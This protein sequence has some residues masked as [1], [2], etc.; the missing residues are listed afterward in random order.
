MEDAYV[1]WGTEMVSLVQ[2]I[3]T[4]ALDQIFLAITRL[5]EMPVLLMCAATALLFPRIRWA[6]CAML[7]AF[8]ISSVVNAEIKAT[9]D[10][11]RPSGHEVYT[12]NNTTTSATPS[13]HT[14][15]A[16]A[17]WFLLALSLP[18][19]RWAV[20][21]IPIV[22]GFTRVYLGMHYPGDVILGLALGALLALSLLLIVE[23]ASGRLRPWELRT[24]KIK[25]PGL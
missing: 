7:A 14:M 12:A 22:V 3:R 20:G 15:S 5:G 13:A 24:R 25:A 10:I 21:A 8:L 16:A 23:V 11:P 2:L 17:V 6:G 4:P 18:G 9:L 19:W 1:R